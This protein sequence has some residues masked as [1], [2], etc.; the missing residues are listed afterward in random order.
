MWR[1]ACTE[2]AG[3]TVYKGKRIVFLG[4]IKATISRVFYN[5]RKALSA[6]F[7]PTTIPIFR[8]QSARFV[9]FIQ[10]SREMFD[11]DSEG[12][13]EIMFSRVINGFLPDLFK[14]WDRMSARH[15]VTIVMF[16][17]MVYH[18]S[19]LTGST[20]H[21]PQRSL[22][23]D[24]RPRDFYRVVVSDMAS[25]Q[26]TTILRQL[27][28]EF[29]VFLRDVSMQGADTSF[30]LLGNKDPRSKEGPGSF[31]SFSKIAGHP[32]AAC[33]GN[34]LEAIN[35]ASTQF[36]NDYLDRDL[37]RTGLSV[38]IVTPGT[39]VF[40]VDYNMLV[41]TTHSL[42]RSGIA[43]DLVCL[44]DKT[45]LHSVPLF[46]Y[47]LPTEESKSKE[48]KNNSPRNDRQSVIRDPLRL[49][50][51]GHL[52]SLASTITNPSFDM[53]H[54]SLMT[55]S[56][57]WGYGIPHWM[58]V[59]FWVSATSRKSHNESLQQNYL[60]NV[61]TEGF[62]PRVRMYELQNIGIM[63]R[64][65]EGISVRYLMDDMRKPKKTRSSNLASNTIPSHPPD[66]TLPSAGRWD[67]LPHVENSNHSQPQKYNSAAIR[68]S[69]GLP[70]QD[71]KL[72]A[73]E[74]YDRGIF[75]VREKPVR[76]R[77]SNSRLL[78]D[79]RSSLLGAQSDSPNPLHP[80]T[81][82][83]GSRGTIKKSKAA[84]PPNLSLASSPVAIKSDNTASVA[85]G[86]TSFR[87]SRLN[88]QI[89]YGLRGL[90]VGP[91]KAIASTEISHASGAPELAVPS[92]SSIIS[93]ESK[94]SPLLSA[95]KEK[96]TVA[97]HIPSSPKGRI[98][99]KDDQPS[100]PIPINAKESTQS[101][102]E[103]SSADDRAG[104]FSSVGTRFLRKQS[105][106]DGLFL[107]TSG[108]RA[109]P[110]VK[111]S[112]SREIR[113]TL[114]PKHALSP[115]LTLLNPSNPDK[116]NQDVASRFGGRW[117]HVYPRTLREASVKWRSLCSPAAVPLT[118]AAFP[119]ARQL[120]SDYVQTTYR[121]SCN[122]TASDLSEVPT[123]RSDLM[124]ELIGNRLSHGLQLVIGPD[125]A[126]ATGQPSL[127]LVDVFDIEAISR[128]GSVTYM[129]MGQVIHRLLCVEGNEVEVTRFTRK[130]MAALAQATT[131]DSPTL[132]TAMVR[133]ALAPAYASRSF[134]FSSLRED[135]NWNALDLFTTGHKERSIE[136]SDQLRFWKARFV[137]I[138]VDIPSSR[139][140]LSTE[141]NEEEIRLEGIKFLT[142]QWQRHR[143]VAPDDRRFQ[144]V[145]IKKKDANPL[146]I[147]YNTSNPS[148]LVRS[149]SDR[150]A[151]VESQN[152]EGKPI[153]LLPESELFSRRELNLP[154]LAAAIQGE[155]GI[156]MM[157]RRWHWRMHHNC[158]VGSEL[159][160]WLLI[161]FRD[162]D[163]REEAETFGNVLMTSGLFQHVERRHNFRDGNYFYQF[164]E[165][166]NARP[167]SRG[168]W[169]SSTRSKGS[170]PSTP[171]QGPVAKDSPGS[172]RS[173][174]E[175]NA[176]KSSLENDTLTPTRTSKTKLEVALSKV[177]RVHIDHRNNSRRLE[178][179][180]L[181]YDRLHNPDNCFHF[182]ID[183][184][185]SVTSKFI[186]DAIVSWASSVER[187]GLRLV[188]VPIAE[189]A[190]ISNLEPFRTP[191]MIKP[192]LHPP[193]PMLR[194]VASM[195][196]NVGTT[197]AY[198]HYYSLI[199]KRFD[200]VLDL[201][202]ANDFPTDVDVKYSWGRPDFRYPQYIHKSG[203]L[204][205]QITDDGQLLLLANRLFQT[206]SASGRDA[207][208]IERNDQMFW[209][210]GTHERSSP[211][212][213]PMVRAT[214]DVIVGAQGRYTSNSLT[215]TPEMIKNDLESF[216]LSKEKMQAFY[217]HI[218]TRESSPP[219][220]RPVAED[221]IPSLGLPESLVAQEL[222]STFYYRPR[223]SPSTA[224]TSSPLMKSQIDR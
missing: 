46:K 72:Q 81:S 64:E 181:H 94:P 84:A 110:R 30:T 219:D 48:S 188:E 70:I 107:A 215:T 63:E 114:S 18:Q 79:R 186:E 39:A 36:S 104:S 222:N 38:A 109:A 9:L 152:S 179:V 82:T 55:S 4:T 92:N 185:T 142:Q 175:S 211:H 105:S 174:A 223:R 117:Q 197:P 204:L 10:M 112:S 218:A 57:R 135:Y 201:E 150:L 161:S 3:Q 13:G 118:T 171:L 95:R 74:G 119:S 99:T 12:T 6:L 192:A 47:P 87:S 144:P 146:D 133:T 102:G 96:T 8:S 28:R 207:S 128:D 159:T 85:K 60:S 170:V 49:A 138:P 130:P 224:R 145:A 169:F 83:A 163:T 202:A 173:R 122:D 210:S 62:V 22:T 71:H 147:I 34:I 177:M 73:M 98:S 123:T 97:V 221:A 176:G 67:L 89:S 164:T 54:L 75:G 11:F 216:V 58:D 212:P 116:D 19:S 132:Y 21:L 165:T 51:S 80:A 158:F 66:I 199:L 154:N 25:G 198:V 91:P 217:D 69:N 129:S 208:K 139:R 193:S 206:R 5:G 65:V 86:A 113:P 148:E 143:Y 56:V 2:L 31:G 53:Q 136:T 93:S 203:V 140:A 1:L 213:S 126:R 209:R 68:K 187:F 127:H 111:P 61:T 131:H 141:D 101:D 195:S 149:E 23:P 214:S 184:P 32:T 134:D 45:P 191:Y 180:D 153:Q 125:V 167:Q 108:R 156:R 76:R 33:Q 220:P 121:L 205:V 24:S 37:V 42:T 50:E 200:F 182:R 90:G 166:Y 178:L 7:S 27:K 20:A 16:T 183:W 29:R 103:S 194:S 41:S 106:T 190:E 100:K 15:L 115:W 35:L 52:G 43:V 17:R 44:T 26:W 88:R 162:I 14:R 124:Q 120:D 155:K 168:G 157:D 59:S 196:D 189:A 160:T 151:T 77:S 78:Q 172:F 137:L 40:E